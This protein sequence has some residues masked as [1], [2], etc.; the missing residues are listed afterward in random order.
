ML[1]VF[2]WRFDSLSFALKYETITTAPRRLI[3]LNFVQDIKTLCRWICEENNGLSKRVLSYKLKIFIVRS[4]E[5][6]SAFLQKLCFQT[7][8]VFKRKFF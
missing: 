8:V 1:M 7:A 6:L 2:L 4:Q 3:L 5:N